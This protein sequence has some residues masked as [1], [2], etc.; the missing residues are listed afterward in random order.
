MKCFSCGTEKNLKYIPTL[1]W[2]FC[3]RCFRKYLEK[4]IKLNIRY[5]R[6]IFRE[7]LSVYGIR[8]LTYEFSRKIIEEIAR[9]KRVSV[10]FYE[11][12]FFEDFENE[13]DEISRG[14]IIIPSELVG[15]LILLKFMGRDIHSV[16]LSVDSSKEIFNVAYNF[17]EYELSLY[18]SEEPR[19]TYFKGRFE[20]DVEQFYKS[21]VEKN[22]KYIRSMP[23]G[24]SYL[25][26]LLFDKK[27]I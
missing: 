22:P 1:G 15:I 18:L 3:D 26:N 4:K 10:D 13:A 27:K 17:S 16:F 20:L 9:K 2:Y 24:L 21:I 6:H 5:S 8:S 14:Y 19:W 23:S 25:Q 12:D 7:N 11:F